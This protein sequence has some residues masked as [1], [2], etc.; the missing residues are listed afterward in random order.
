MFEIEF[1]A[2]F[3][4]EKF[5]ALKNYL[6][7]YAKCLGE[8]NKD[9]YYYIF[10]DKLLKVVNNTSKKTAKISLKLNHIGNG[11]AFPEM[12]VYFSP[13]QFDTAKLLVDSLGLPAKVMHGPQ[14]RIDYRYKD[15]EIALKYSDAW[16]YHLEIEQV[17]KTKEEQPKAEEKIR[18]VA[19]ELGVRLM[20]EEELKRFTQEAESKIK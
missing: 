6:D 4:K 3:S 1:R 12:E 15:C 5:N 19:D 9:C 11:A 18:K 17:V 20:S 16:G 10:P 8:N 2:R 13:Q 7:E 14:Q